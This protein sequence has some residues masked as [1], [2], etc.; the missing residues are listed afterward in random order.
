[1]FVLSAA[2]CGWGGV[3]VEPG[4]VVGWVGVGTLLSPEASAVRQVS[5]PVRTGSPLGGLAWVG[6]FLVNWIVDASI[7]ATACRHPE[8]FP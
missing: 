5:W 3:G 4:G 1:M 6:V 8:P 7:F 2:C